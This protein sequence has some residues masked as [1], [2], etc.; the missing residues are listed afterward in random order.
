[1]PLSF[2]EGFQNPTLVEKNKNEFEMV[3]NLTKHLE[4]VVKVVPGR[5][6]PPHLVCGIGHQRGLTITN[7]IGKT[8][9]HHK[10]SFV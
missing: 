5:I 6:V 3:E 2:E 8:F 9:P 10:P 7:H 1:M 4:E